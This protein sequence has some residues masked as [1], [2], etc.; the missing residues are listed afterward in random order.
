MDGDKDLNLDDQREAKNA[1]IQMN[2]FQIETEGNDVPDFL[3]GVNLHLKQA[4][5]D[6][7]FTLTI[8]EDTQ[9]ISG[10][11]KGLID[12]VN[13]VLG[14][15]GSQ[16][17]IDQSTD[18]TST[19]A[20]DT[21]LTNIEYRLR[22]LMQE[23]FPVGTPGE[24]GF[25]LVHL[26]ELGVEFD[27]TG[28]LQFKE[29]KFQKLLEKDFDGISQAITGEFGF[30]F[31]LRSTIQSYTQSGTGL[32]GVR[33]RG[34]QA[35]IKQIDEQIDQKAKR[36]EQRQQ[37]LTDQFSRLEGS[38]ANM[39]RQQAALGALGGGGGLT[40]QLLGGG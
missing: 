31:Q 5:S 14:F 12:Q 2:G 37:S 36:L 19:F 23:A 20:G 6:K 24:E 22:N 4:A 13:G 39:Q 38:M 33:E 26:N 34:I 1:K 17:K 7:P 21:S 15:I 11:I 28:T 3:P 18:T 10:K 16:N 9:K 25:R 32:L 35:R 40:Q 29:D 8:T 30:A 27:K